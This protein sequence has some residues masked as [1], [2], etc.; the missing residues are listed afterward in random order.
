MLNLIYSRWHGE[1]Q[2]GR[3]VNLP[4]GLITDVSFIFETDAIQDLT[5]AFG[6]WDFAQG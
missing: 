1:I 5:S 2:V 6:D 3:S 4:S